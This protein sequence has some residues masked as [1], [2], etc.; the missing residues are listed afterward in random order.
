MTREKIK[1]TFY[2]LTRFYG[3]AKKIG[4][5]V[6]RDCLTEVFSQRC[7]NDIRR[8]LESFII[9]YDNKSY[10]LE[11]KIKKNV[12]GN[13]CYVTQTYYVCSDVLEQ[14]E[15]IVHFPDDLKLFKKKVKQDGNKFYE[16]NG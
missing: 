13:T 14:D 7:P 16:R 11:Y 12:T 6:V 10:K 8:N 1:A 15:Y 9:S 2:E 4:S 5:Y 3:N